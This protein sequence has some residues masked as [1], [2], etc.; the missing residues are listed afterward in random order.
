MSQTPA[1]QQVPINN[2]AKD[3]S[4]GND[5]LFHYTYDELVA[6]VLAN[7]PG[8]VAKLNINTQFFFGDSATD[9][10][11]LQDQINYLTSDKVGFSYDTGTKVF[12]IDGD[13]QNFDYFVQMGNKGTWS[14]ANVDVTNP[15]AHLGDSLFTEDFD[16]YQGQP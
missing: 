16:T 11:T 9:P 14:E 7:D 6:K 10:H 3:D 13:T 4:I 12:T 8:S 1:S 15:N 2:A 5:G